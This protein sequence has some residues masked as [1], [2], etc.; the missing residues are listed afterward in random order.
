MPSTAYTNRLV[1]EKSPYLLQHAH[2]PVDWYPWGDEAFD[3]ARRE[4]KIVLLSIGYSTCH[5]CH[6]MERESFED[7]Q[8]AAVI[9]TL[10]VPIKVDREERPDLD[11]VYMTV[12][13]ALTGSGG[14]P[15]TVLLTPEGKPFF[16]GTY[17][18]KQ[19]VP[20]RIGL[21]D[22]LHRAAALWQED[23]D[24]VRRSAG[25]I[26]DKLRAASAAPGEESPLSEALFDRAEEAFRD[27]FDAARGGFGPAPKFPTPHNLTFL[28]R[29]TRRSGRPEGRRMARETL[30]AMRRGGV[31]DQVGFG[32]HRYATDAG[33][34]L[35]HFEKM[36][37]DQA[38]LA[39]AYLEAYQATGELAH[40]RTAREIFTYVRRDLTDPGGAFYS[41]E[42]ADSEGVEGKFYVWTRA[43]ILEALGP[44]DGELFCRLFGVREEG[45]FRDEATGAPTGANVLHLPRPLE[46]WA[47]EVGRSAEALEAFVEAARRRLFDRR[48]ARVRPH[49]DDKIL[50]GWNGLMISA[51]AHGAR[52]LG[53]PGYAEAAEAAAAF[54]LGPLRPQGRLRRRF[55]DGEAAVDAFA[56]DYAFLVRGLLDLYGATF[57][58]E[59]L[60]RALELAE[61]LVDRF[62][63]EEAGGLYDT[64][65]DAESLILRPKGI[66]DGAV[67]SANSA[68]LEGF[69]R[70]GLLTGDPRWADRARALAQTFA[71]Q[72]AAY[73]AAFCQFLQGLGYLLGPTREVVLVGDPASREVRGFL[74]VLRESY[75]PETTVLAVPPGDAARLRRLAPFTEGMEL[76]EGRPAAYVCRGFACGR[77]VT[78]VDELRD[79]L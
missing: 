75:F 9:N 20:G 22:L 50:T 16:A 32:F 67:P 8:V 13:Q 1:R 5:W 38:G 30:A 39:L 7:P 69:A 71:A 27:R 12:C 28:L 74:Q 59:H 10:T 77:P 42:D 66:Y 34:L 6:V 3:K 45:N 43:E 24:R 29:H 26:V 68:A 40:A 58:A 44:E 15:L 57:A 19:S 36:L 79:A 73:P 11:Q 54:L 78:E 72:V 65:A 52:V 33:W 76:V 63:D 35:P 70:L 55:R 49:R 51:L 64:A 37:Y 21:V 53:E 18:P 47:P 48:Q 62:W 2:N 4:D 25:E 60:E 41:A 23:P 56:E 17:F 61:E 14:W 31:F 46:A